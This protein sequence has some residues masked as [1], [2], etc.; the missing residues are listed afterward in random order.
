MNRQ[1][2]QLKRYLTHGPEPDCTPFDRYAY[3]VFSWQAAY[4]TIHG[5]TEQDRAEAVRLRDLANAKSREM[6]SQAQANTQRT[7]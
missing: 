1:L 3:N 5:K 2:R 7:R 6:Q 4:W